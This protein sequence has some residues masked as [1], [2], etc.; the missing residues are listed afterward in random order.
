MH[1][2]KVDLG[3]PKLSHL[4]TSF[5]KDVIWMWQAM[6]RYIQHVHIELLDIA[7]RQTFR[8]EH[9]DWNVGIVL[10]L[11]EVHRLEPIVRWCAF[12]NL[13]QCAVLSASAHQPS[14]PCMETEDVRIT[15]IQQP[16]QQVAFEDQ[17]IEFLNQVLVDVMHEITDDVLRR[18]VGVPKMDI[19]KTRTAEPTRPFAVGCIHVD[20]SYSPVKLLSPV[21]AASATFTCGANSGAIT[22]NL[23]FSSE[24]SIVRP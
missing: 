2:R 4:Q 20:Y 21:A 1:N 5:L 15:R 10:L 24:M 16:I 3:N 22:S 11:D 12:Q 9:I 18:S 23:F 19:P 6:V 7:N 13:Q 14:S 8:I 17:H